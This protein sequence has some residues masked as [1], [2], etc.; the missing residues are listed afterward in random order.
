LLWVVFNFVEVRLYLYG[1]PEDRIIVIDSDLGK[2]GS[3]TAGRE[4][5]K[6]L[7]SEVGMGNAGIIIGLE[8]SRLARNSSD[9][10]R[11]LEICALTKTL[12][13]NVRRNI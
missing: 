13:Q 5:F 9:W 4:G 10:H 11:L 1:E 8:V 7:V 12:I 3:S 6:K 2:S